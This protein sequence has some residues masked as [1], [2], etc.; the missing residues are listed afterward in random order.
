MGSAMAGNLLD[1]DLPLVVWN[2]TPARAAAVVA[3]GA[4]LAATPAEAV[5][6]ADVVVVSLADEPAQRDVLLTRTL[7]ALRAGTWLVDT[8][9]VSPT[10]SREVTAR[11]AGHGVTRV[12]ACVLG[13]PEQA[14]AGALRVFAGGPAAHVEAVRDVLDVLG[15]QVL[16]VGDTGAGATLKLVFN[17]LLGAQVTSLAEGVAY[18]VGAGLDRDMLLTAVAESGFSSLVMSFR[19]Q[20]MRQRSYTP[21]AFRSTLM[22]KDLA[23]AL[24]EAA[25]L[26]VDLPVTAAAAGRFAEVARRGDGDADAAVVVEHVTGRWAPGPRTPLPEGPR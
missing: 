21:A 3:A 26:G 9:T 23:L 25:G 7:P 5:A 10:W 2:R 22:G 20:I 17:L 24:S 18:G 8:S 14:R 4:R 16:H 13:N 12:E 19:A 6:G 11:L 15:H 1:N